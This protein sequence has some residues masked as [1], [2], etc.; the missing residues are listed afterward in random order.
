MEL[1][2]KR[3]LDNRESTTGQLYIAGGLFCFTL[4]DPRQDHKIKG[5][6]RI[7]PGR[8]R[9]KLRFDTPMADRYEKK[10]RT[11]GMLELQNV[12]NFSNIYLHIGNDEDDTAGCIL[13]GAELSQKVSKTGLDQRILYSK[14]TYLYLWETIAPYIPDGVYITILD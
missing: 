9:I 13:V 12:A 4:E 8:Y 1:I 3:G 14:D 6:T 10:L 5:K 7:S 2:L 11:S